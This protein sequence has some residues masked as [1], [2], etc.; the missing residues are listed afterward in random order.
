MSPADTAPRGAVTLTTSRLRLTMPAPDH[1]SR[2]VTYLEDNRDHLRRWSG[3]EP[4]GFY[5][6]PFWQ[7]QL[8]RYR[9]EYQDGRSLR[10][11]VAPADDPD[12]VIGT[13]G[14]SNVVRGSFQAC[15]L[16]YAIDHRFE[17]RGLMCEA[18]EAAIDHVFAHEQLHRIMANY[19]PTNERSGA[20]L[21]RL[22]FHVEGYARDYL[23][24]NGMWRDHILTARHNPN[25]ASPALA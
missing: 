5:T 6:I 23:F 21:R 11:M 22:G 3:L 17:R 14:F 24:I 15:H 2:V 12:R 1:A 9:S 19:M 13:V 25:A 16:G 4:D 8:E 20:L 18:L 7:Q 10:L